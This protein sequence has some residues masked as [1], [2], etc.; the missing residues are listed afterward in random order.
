MMWTTSS[1]TAQTTL[2]PRTLITFEDSNLKSSNNSI[3]SL[4]DH[5]TKNSAVEFLNK[6]TITEQDLGLTHEKYSSQYKGVPIEFGSYSV[7]K[8]ETGIFSI[9]GTPFEANSLST[10]PLI[11]PEKGLE[12]AL[13]HVNADKYLWE[14]ENPD[15]FYEGYEKPKGQL[16]ILPAIPGISEKPQL[17][18]KYFVYSVEPMSAVYFYVSAHSGE[19]V[20]ENSIIC[21]SNIAASGNA[22]YNGSVTFQA[23]DFNGSNRLFNTVIST[24]G[25]HTVK[26]IN[27]P[28][29]TID[30]TSNT[31][32]FSDDIGVQAHWAAEKTV[33]YFSAVHGR[34]SYDGNGSKISVVT[35]IPNYN[36]AYWTGTTAVFGN[37]DGTT[38][39]NFAS[40]DIVGHEITHG[41]VGTSAGLV[42]SYEPG[43][44]NESFADI[45]GESIEGYATGSVDW[46]VGE[47]LKIGSGQALRSMSN[48]N[49][50]NHP[51]TYKGTHWVTSGIDNGGVHTNSSVQNHWFYLLVNGG[52]G[53]NDWGQTYSITGIGA[54]KAEAIAYRNLTVYLTA[55]S[56]FADARAGAIQSAIDLYGAGSAEEIAVTNSW[57]AVGVG[58]FYNNPN[59][60]ACNTGSLTLII[61]FDD[62]P[63]LISWHI[64][65][66]TTGNFV[67]SKAAGDY[68]MN[69][70][71]TTVTETINLTSSGLYKFNFFDLEADGLCC[72]G[73]FGS[74]SL[75]EGNN[76]IASGSSFD[77]SENFEF[78]VN[79]TS[80][81]S[82]ETERPTIPQ[83]LVAS[84]VTSTSADIS[85]TAST[86]NSGPVLYYLYLNGE[87]HHFAFTT[88]ATIT[89]LTPASLNSINVF[90]LDMNSNFSLKSN[91]LMI[92]TPNTPDASPPSTPTNLV[93]SNI[94]S[95]G[96]DLSWDP[97]T[98]N[99]G[100]DHY[101]IYL[102]GIFY[103][104]TTNTSVSIT[105]LTPSTSYDNYV[106][107]FDAAGNQSSSSAVLTTT[108]TSTG[109]TCYSGIL[110][111]IITFDN[112]PDQMAWE[113]KDKN[114]QIYASS[115]LNSYANQTPGSTV[116]IKLPPL[117]DGDYAFVMYD[118][119][120]NGI[121]CGSGNGSYQITDGTNVLVSGSMYGFS[122][123]TQFCYNQSNGDIVDQT[124]PS[125]P[126][127]S[128]SNP[129]S[130]TV[131]ISWTASTDNEQVFS[132]LFYL[133]G[134]YH[135]YVNYSATSATLTGLA[136]NT[137]YEFFIVARDVIGNFSDISNYVVF[138][139]APAV[140]STVIHEGY[141]E[142]GW[143]GWIDGGNDCRRMTTQY[144]AEGVKSVRIRDNSGVAS[145]MTSQDFDL[146]SVD[147]VRVDFEYYAQSME[148]NE[149][150]W[151]RF[152]QNN[153]WT[154]VKAYVKNIDFTSN[155][156]YSGSVVL[157]ASQYAFASDSKF[158]FQC[159][160]SGNGDKIYIDA[161]IITAYTTGSSALP[162]ITGNEF[163]KE[164]ISKD[165]KIETQIE[166][167]QGVRVDKNNFDISIYPNPAQTH[168]NIKTED[169]NEIES[170]T[171]FDAMGRKLIQSTNSSFIDISNLESGIF[172]VRIS[173]NDQSH[174][175]L[176]FIKVE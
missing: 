84:N 88:F 149:D 61:T 108:T 130:T 27:G 78:C 171:I 93:A 71:N 65:D 138:T 52:N 143:D 57:Y 1:I 127:L 64:S 63:D 7:H 73:G 2:N 12:E 147:S 43:A 114:N 97:S 87:L 124:P 161:V 6:T 140:T 95:S 92:L 96:Y 77:I 109:P 20:F 39:D 14:I 126:V 101:D 40:L 89:G 29:N 82:I 137:T 5:F 139:T 166:P 51:D 152:Y 148:N 18:Y 9:S 68:A 74:F 174:H 176:K 117:A 80:G 54:A 60:A 17:T 167:L 37:G 157:K 110:S 48:P 129:T 112:N 122:E 13:N 94:T 31:S 50:F 168:I 150:F 100:V 70:A 165:E 136:P 19:I 107:A 35:N 142:S 154:T 83:N 8:N 125:N 158:R 173:F 22:Y 23:E 79:V 133:N 153:S 102:D 159:D 170:V 10:I 116:N 105:G 132:Y 62:R 56:G 106:I 128:Y 32:V 49:S 69:L 99:I 104:S 111:L 145:S 118:Y 131:D 98:D 146:S 164:Y 113:L 135:G 151:L 58:T 16:V 53:S 30:I 36:N 47:D 169:I 21:H 75:A 26:A 55:T 28:T 91:T 172:Y 90:A 144:S 33:D 155:G 85:W 66:N 156:F 11:A 25:I 175:A 121:C 72:T 45:F 86:D 24:G 59:P 160:A 115:A 120:G 81:P 119:G 103:A 162:I 67:A 15:I 42:Y 134:E 41:V 76:V 163:D 44:L 34:S 38:Y 3:E 141:F 123:V 46:L 4:R